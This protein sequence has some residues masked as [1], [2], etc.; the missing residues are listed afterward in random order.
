MHPWAASDRHFGDGSCVGG[1]AT[2]AVAQGE[3]REP[4]A[5]RRSLGWVLAVGLI[6]AS[7]YAFANWT[8]FHIPIPGTED[9][10][11]RPQYALLT[12]FGFAFGPMVGLVTGFVGNLAG[13]WL[14]G[15]NVSTAWPWSV[16]NGLVGLL[17]GLAALLLVTRST[18]VRRRA[19]LAGLASVIATVV[20]FLFVWVEL[21]TQ[22]ELG[23]DY[24]L[25]REYLPTIIVNSI[26]AAIATPIIILAWEP[27]RHDAA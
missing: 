17:S 6:G 18:P 3:L 8:T 20:G 19:Y 5:M 9:V 7:L 26:F 2:M 25:S 15:T 11:I 13:D 14:S 10:S 21:V 27:I 16:A 1:A 23:F 24:I 12:F 22:P 4:D